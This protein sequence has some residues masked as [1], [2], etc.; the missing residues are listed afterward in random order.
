[1]SCLSP[2]SLKRT[3]ASQIIPKATWQWVKA[4]YPGEHPILAFDYQTGG[5]SPQKGTS[6]IGSDPVQHI[7]PFDF[8]SKRKNN[9]TFQP[10]KELAPQ[11]AIKAAA[12]G[13]PA[14]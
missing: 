2:E 11:L 13:G 4:P 7:N 12:G 6:P 5:S 1:M 14:G 8:V 3:C 10:L 9:P